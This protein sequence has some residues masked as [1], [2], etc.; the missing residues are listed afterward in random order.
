I[1]RTGQQHQHRAVLFDPLAGC[2]ATIVGQNLRTIDNVGLAAIDLDHLSLEATEALFNLVADILA[3]YH[4]AA[5]RAGYG[6]AREIVFGRT[7]STDRK[8]T[9]LNSSHLGIS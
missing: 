1:G 6:I 7:E 8:S 5:E 4:G 9:R 3:E 2:S